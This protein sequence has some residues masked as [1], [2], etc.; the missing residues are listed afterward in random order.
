VAFLRRRK[1][2]PEGLS[3][4]VETF[5]IQLQGQGT[6][7]LGQLDGTGVVRVRDRLVCDDAAYDIRSFKQFQK[8][9]NEAHAGM[10]VGIA[11]GPGT[12]P[13]GFNGKTVT[14]RRP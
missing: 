7:L 14:F 8:V 12:S 6:V 4:L 9:L 3:L 10:N 2:G 1:E 5:F 13:D 11:L